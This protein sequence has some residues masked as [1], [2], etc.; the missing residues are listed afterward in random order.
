MRL[1]EKEIIEELRKSSSQYRPLVIDQL[2]E[3]ARPFGGFQADAIVVVSFVD[4]PCFKALVEIATIATPKSIVEKCRRLLDY[5]RS[6]DRP[7]LVPLL[8][9]PYIGSRQANILTAEGVS[10]LDLCGNMCVNIPS[11]IYIE[12]TGNKNKYPDTAP[13]KKIFQGI[14]SLVSRALLLRP[15]GF[16]SQ[17]ELVDFINSRG[18]NITAATVSRVLKSLEEDLLIRKTK[19]LISA[20]DAEKLLD[21]LTG[22]YIDYTKRRRAKPYKF[23]ADEISKVFYVFFDRQVAN[24]ACGF[25][26]AKLRGLAETDQVILFVKDVQKAKKETELQMVEMIP[27]AEF[28]QLSLIETQDPCVWFNSSRAQPFTPGIIDD[29]ELYLEMVID[30]PRGP[31]IAKSLK[32]RILKGQIDG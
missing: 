4:K 24:V 5:I 21:N 10:W 17:Y 13:I 6:L 26:A 22:D 20:I 9:A 11:K 14:S 19:S 29:I 15:K 32:S 7:E 27:D 31:K 23:A 12:R 3:Q 28:G 1:T 25:Y 30:T 8:I 18:A 2:Y 16:K